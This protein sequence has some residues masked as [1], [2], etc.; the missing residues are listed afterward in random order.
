MPADPPRAPGQFAFA[1]IDYVTDILDQA[2]L[3]AIEGAEA[4][5]HLLVPGTAEDAADLATSIGP[6]AVLLREKNGT[7][8]DRRAITADVAHKLGAFAGPD[9]VRIPAILNLFSARR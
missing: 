1:E 6:V 5:T 3:S 8:D 4:E 9:G 2:G 7:E